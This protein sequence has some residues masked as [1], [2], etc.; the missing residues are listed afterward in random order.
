MKQVF[1]FRGK[2]YI[3]KILYSLYLFDKKTNIEITNT[4][5]AIKWSTVT[6]ICSVTKTPID[7]SSSM[8]LIG[9]PHPDISRFD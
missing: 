6:E 4:S 9:S 2:G 5:G 7:R 3:E 1:L 8:L